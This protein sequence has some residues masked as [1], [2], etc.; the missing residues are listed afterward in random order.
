[1]VDVLLQTKLYMPPSRPDWV[2]R[3]RLLSKLAIQ[4]Q[5]KLIL[6]SAPAGYGKTTLV[7][8]WLE[9]LRLT[10]SDLRLDGKPGANRQSEIVNQ[11][12]WLSLDED[13]SDPQHFF[14]YVAE[15]IRPLPNAQTSL[16]QFLQSTQPIPAKTLAKALIN[17]IA[18]V[19]TPFYLILDDYHAVN[20][21]EVDAGLA[22][23]L[24]RMPPNM[25]LVITSR[26]D[27][28]FPISRLRARGQ[29]IE[30]RADD[31]RFT[32]A[33]AAQFLQQTMGITLT[34]D[35]VAALEKRTE[36]WVAG[37]Q[38]AALS[39]QNR[40]S[41][42][43]D[44]F[45]NTFTGSHRFILD[46]LVEEALLQQSESMREFLLATC[47]LERL[48]G[49]LCDAVTGNSNSQS[50]LE[51]L[52]QA[53]LFVVSLDDQ[54]QWYR[55]HHLFAE[56]LHAH[57]RANHSEQ[58]TAWHQQASSWFAEQGAL[59]DA[60]QHALAAN[61]HSEAARL[62]ELIH[63]QIDGTYQ[64]Q[65]WLSLAN[66]LPQS[67]VQQR[68]I[69]SAAFGWALL[70]TGDIDA[71]L[72]HFQQAEQWLTSPTADMVVSD[73]EQWRVLPAS[74]ANAHAYRM[75]AQGDVVGA[76]QQA[77][78][79]LDFFQPDETHH[80]RRVA[81]SMLGITHWIVGDIPASAQAFADATEEFIQ[82]GKLVDAISTAFVLAEFQ[83]MLGQL[84]QAEQTVRRLLQLNAKLDAPL[85]LGADDLYRVLAYLAWERGD[86]ET[87][88]S[89][90]KTAIQASE[91]GTF[92]NGVYRLHLLQ[93]VFKKSEGAF[94]ASLSLLDEAESVFLENPL[95]VVRPL[96]AL[97]AD[98]W[99]AQGELT[100]AQTWVAAQQLTVD[101]DVHYLNEFELITFVRLLLAQFQQNNNAAAL[102][103]AMRLLDRLLASAEEGQRNN[104]VLKILLLQ[105]TALAQQQ[106]M[107]TAMGTF[108]RAL[109]LAEPQGYVKVFVGEGRIMAGLL[110]TAVSQ[111]IAPA[112]AT[113]LLAAFGEDAGETFVQQSLVDP[114]TDRELEILQ[115][116]AAGLKNQEIADQLFIT[117]NT[118]LYHN[119]NIYSKLGVRKRALAIAKARELGLVS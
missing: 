30:L 66:Q 46:Y 58:M 71:S 52:E 10:I 67:L 12:C 118:V 90:L 26:S 18:L 106:D 33:E 44:S 79:A 110:K 15:A 108:E 37:L 13:D 35:Q 45:V 29:L 20:S 50:I 99:I 98:V 5:T 64:I 11:A 43:L 34:L 53:N 48:N 49:S 24:D 76:T 59:Q 95:P 1:M 74:L 61:A 23:L 88:V 104:S 36:G 111:N 80:W 119:K 31:M 27:P 17:D 19:D 38:M 56:M 82:A 83:I 14:R 69:L 73:D 113:R 89:H 4:P 9:N 81:L 109:T 63:F 68:P 116:I 102:D 105:S 2:E 65:L 55:Y 70:E 91:S 115:H 7:T 22:A 25:T 21:P 57:A 117:L 42:D 75:M 6:I 114:L 101:T 39:M 54:R 97:R 93:A 32:Q 77:Q 51:M 100:K 84:Y 41:S 47:I 92:T 28:G 94:D 16:A 78:Q 60:I 62:L 87:A 72:P 85:S 8:S 107:A 103:D 96:A 112:Y 3:P 86:E 40:Q